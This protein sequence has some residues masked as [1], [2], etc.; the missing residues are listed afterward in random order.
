MKR[1][2]SLC[3]I[4]SF[5]SFVPS[6]FAAGTFEVSGWI[7][8]WR[9]A[10][11]TAETLAHLDAF[12]EINPFGY[13]VTADGHLYDPTNFGAEPW[14]TLI[15]NA[16]AKKIRIIPTIMWG[17]GAA[18][19]ATLSNKTLRN[20]HIK[21]IVNL[22]NANGFD[23]VDIDYEAKL[24]ET[25]DYYSIFL[26]DLYKAMG[27]KWVQCEIES[28][29]P[30]TSR[31][32]TVPA[33]Y[34]AKDVSN[35]YKMINKYCDR[36]RIMAYD[37]GRVDLKLDQTNPGIYAPIA[38]PQWVKKVV[39]LAAKEISKKKII[40][41]I[42]TYGYEYTITP[43]G[44]GGYT[45]ERLWA[46]NP[47]YALQIAAPLNLMPT[48]TSSG[49]LSFTFYP[50]ASST[51]WNGVRSDLKTNMLVWSDAYSIKQKVDLA[52]SLGLRG[53]AIF[54]IDGGMDPYAWNYLK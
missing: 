33:D 24:T 4:L 19:H 11:G 37:Q 16:K 48:R 26:R 1:I 34:N 29:T 13:T 35:D 2:V 22:V 39:D 23:G 3:I 40:L 6:A 21:E 27:K 45:Y 9:S 20:A 43:G 36:V 38:D 54:K 7:P 44:V 31:Y 51:P 46:F 30:V 50:E 18:I 28:R 10:T 49:E 32:D 25:K 42:P 15:N 8:Y 53:V 17:N 52:K 47:L 41:G 14:T 5:F 12:K